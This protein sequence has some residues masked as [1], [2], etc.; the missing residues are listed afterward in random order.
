VPLQGHWKKVNTPL[1][2]TTSRERRIL[3]AFA[4]LLAIGAIAAIIVAIGSS[5]PATPPGCIRVE[6]PSTMGGVSSDLCGNTARQFCLGPAANS[7]PLDTQVQPK[8]R[9]A[10]YPVRPQ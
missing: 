10:G 2:A 4:A 6:L 5:S 8:C 9:A 1:R 7:E 3:I